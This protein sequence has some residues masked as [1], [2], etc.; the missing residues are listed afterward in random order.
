MFQDPPGVKTVSKENLP[1]ILLESYCLHQ[2]IFRAGETDLTSEC[3]N[4]PVTDFFKMTD[5][6]TDEF[7]EMHTMDNGTLFLLFTC[8]KKKQIEHSQLKLLYSQKTMRNL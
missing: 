5:E 8:D 1:E 4:Q 2:V 6:V 3:L 7:T